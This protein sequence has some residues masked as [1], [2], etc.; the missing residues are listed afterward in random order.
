MKKQKVMSQMKGQDK[1]PEKQLN[2]VEIGNLPEKEFRIT[3]VKMIQD[4]R[5]SMEK[6]QDAYQRPRRTKE[7]TEMNNT[8]EGINSRI[9]EAEEQ[10]N[11][12]EDRMVEITATEQNIEKRM[13][14]NEDSLRDLWDN[15]KCTNIRTIGFP[16]GEEKEKRPEKIFEEIIAENFPNM[17]KEIVN[18]VQEAQRVPGR[19]NPRRNTP[20]HIVIKLT[21]IKDKDKIL[22]ATREK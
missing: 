1:T 20:R 10:I 14:R 21:K 7:K 8:L 22:K 13:K 4:L 18:Q 19:I 3:I 17:G 9:T 5:K 15:I 11:D 16:E 12:L 6:M 2:E